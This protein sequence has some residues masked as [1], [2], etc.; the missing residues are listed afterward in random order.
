MPS[1]F[2]WKSAT[3]NTSTTKIKYHFGSNWVLE[4]TDHSSK[5][6]MYLEQIVI[7]GF[8]DSVITFHIK[9][10][11]TNW[12]GSE[13]L[14]ILELPYKY[15]KS[16]EYGT[17]EMIGDWMR[18]TSKNDI[19]YNSETLINELS[20]IKQWIN[21][22]NKQSSFH[23]KNHTHTNSPSFNEIQLNF[24]NFLIKYSM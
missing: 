7:P 5:S 3:P 11:P 17:L 10:M 23:K 21:N 6:Y 20:K 13:L 4:D 12:V 16:D 22:N 18:F 19:E 9:Q 14:E 1:I 2:I 24:Q 15:I 8:D